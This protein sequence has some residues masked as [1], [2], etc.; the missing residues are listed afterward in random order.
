MITIP[1]CNYIIKLFMR[2]YIIY[3]RI[4]DD[5]L[6]EMQ[7]IYTATKVCI[8]S[9]QNTSKLTNG[10][11]IFDYLQTVHLQKHSKS[12]YIIKKNIKQFIC[13]EADRV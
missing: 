11:K 6:N 1:L 12:E 4:I 9:H 3:Y 2:K 5:I 7:T 8:T 10:E 13:T